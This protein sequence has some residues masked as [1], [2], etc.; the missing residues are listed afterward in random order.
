MAGIRGEAVSRQCVSLHIEGGC[1]GGRVVWE[2][3]YLDSGGGRYK[4]KRDIPI[5][6]REQSL[7]YL[8]KRWYSSLSSQ[9]LSGAAV[10]LLRNCAGSAAE[11]GSHPPF[12][13]VDGT[14]S[15]QGLLQSPV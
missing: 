3:M 12:D 7:S 6:W 13:V 8:V 2:C 14:A 15:G 11:L 5:S 10:L 9:Y 4:G 1:G